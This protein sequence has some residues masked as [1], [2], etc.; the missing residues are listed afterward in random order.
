MKNTHIKSTPHPEDK[1][2]T[3]GG[4]RKPTTNKSK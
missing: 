4:E 2:S 1:H 3:K